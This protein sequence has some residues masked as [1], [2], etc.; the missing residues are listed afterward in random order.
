MNFT[1]ETVNKLWKKNM[2]LAFPPTTSIIWHKRNYTLKYVSCHMTKP[3]KWAVRPAKTQ[4]SLG[5]WSESSLCAQWVAKAP[6]FLHADNEDWLDWACAQRV[7]KA[8]RFLHADNKDSDKTGRMPRLIWVFAGCTGR[9]VVWQLIF[10]LALVGEKH[11][12]QEW[13]C[14][15][16]V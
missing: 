9:F 10:A 15:K 7:A 8:P 1:K 12:N 11:T 16:Y 2:S 14:N 4:I 6:R 3:T 5:I 13:W